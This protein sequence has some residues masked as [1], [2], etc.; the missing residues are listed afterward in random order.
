MKKMKIYVKSTLRRNCKYETFPFEF[1]ARSLNFLML[2]PFFFL[3]LHVSKLA[4]ENVAQRAL[5]ISFLLWNAK[6]S[7]TFPCRLSTCLSFVKRR[8]LGNVY[9][10]DKG[11]E[12]EEGN[13]I[14]GLLMEV[15][16]PMFP[17]LR[18]H[19]THFYCR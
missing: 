17:S 18:Y 12:E 4:R 11:E 1:T 16:E 9:K 7:P 13:H 14:E 8:S 6:I 15:K 10:H 5:E 2:L 19:A 3:L